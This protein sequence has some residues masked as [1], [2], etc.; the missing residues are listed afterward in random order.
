MEHG[1]I[2]NKTAP[3]VVFNLERVALIQP[4]SKWKKSNYELN[5]KNIRYIND[6]YWKKADFN[7]QYAS[8]LPEQQLKHIEEVLEKHG[9]LFNRVLFFDTVQEL[10]QYLD[11]VDGQYL[12]TDKQFLLMVGKRGNYFSVIYESKKGW[13]P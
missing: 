11:D 5:L 12:D 6:S 13:I 2:S 10:K 8:L 9:A 4:I 3:I 7:I 1:N